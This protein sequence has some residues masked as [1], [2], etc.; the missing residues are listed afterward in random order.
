MF[1]H[2]LQLNEE[3]DNPLGLA[4]TLR[5]LGKMQIDQGQKQEARETLET[6]LGEFR[7]LGAQTDINQIEALLE[8]MAGD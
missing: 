7:K 4:E 2:G 8:T 5:D 3:C 1:R 6:A